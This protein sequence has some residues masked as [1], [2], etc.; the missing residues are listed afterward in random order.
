V[1]SSQ[2][3]ITPTFTNEQR[4]DEPRITQK[5]QKSEKI[6]LKNF[7]IITGNIHIKIGKKLISVT[8]ISVDDN[9]RCIPMPDLLRWKDVAQYIA[10]TA[11]RLVSTIKS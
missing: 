9:V 11:N 3:I 2:Y 10:Y 1:K 7:G 6:S 5:C 8:T 4:T